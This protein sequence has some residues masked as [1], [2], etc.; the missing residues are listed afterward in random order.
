MQ[1]LWEEVC[2]VEAPWLHTAATSEQVWTS[3][4][5]LHF[6]LPEKGLKVTYHKLSQISD[7][8]RFHYSRPAKKMGPILLFNNSCSHITKIVFLLSILTFSTH[9][10]AKDTVTNDFHLFRSLQRSLA[11]NLLIDVEEVTAC[12]NHF[13]L[14]ND[15]FLLF[16]GRTFEQRWKDIS[17]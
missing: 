7:N 8:H 6:E 15:A 13:C 11:E 5:V 1:Q 10:K 12:L 4:G 3:S 16:G 2:I 9:H 14:K 17:K